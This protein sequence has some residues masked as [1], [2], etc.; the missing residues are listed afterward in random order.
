[1]RILKTR[2]KVAQPQA[3]VSAGQQ[4]MT[5]TLKTYQY[6]IEVGHSKSGSNHVVIIKS[7]KVRGDDLKQAIQEMENALN[8]F[9]DIIEGA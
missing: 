5:D 3:T 1:M 4:T 2:K 8:S 9:S 6:E 7:L